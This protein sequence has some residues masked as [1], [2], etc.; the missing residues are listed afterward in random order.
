MQR[1]P[2][3]IGDYLIATLFAATLVVITAQVLCRYVLNDSLV[4][5]EELARYLFVWITFIGAALAVKEGTHIRVALIVDRLPSNVRRFLDVAQLVL[6]AAFLGLLVWLGFQW[7][8][9]NASSL[10][11]ALGLPLNYA[12]Y[13]A[14]PVAAILGLYFAVRRLIKVAR[15][16]SNGG[17]AGEGK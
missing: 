5:T 15:T 13:A 16:A 1:R 3:S 12:C 2:M 10:T 6:A 9:L 17:G 8:W 4:W 7:V 11:P 14:L